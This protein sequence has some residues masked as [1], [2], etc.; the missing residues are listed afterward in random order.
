MRP[1]P[2][3][4]C[5]PAHQA[6]GPGQQGQGLLAGGVAGGEQLLVEVEEGHRVGA[7]HPV[8]HGLGADQDGARRARRR[9]SPA[10][11]S[12]T[13][14]PASSS[15]S[16][17]ARVT[18]T[19]SAFIRVAPQAV[20]TAGRVAPQRRQA[21]GAV[22]PASATGPAHTSHRAS[23]PQA[24]HA[25]SGARPLRLRTH[26]TRRSGPASRTRATRRDE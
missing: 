24:T 26:T 20:H 22:R 11:T 16:S 23:S 5:A 12:A 8:Q 4:A 25:S 10:V 2:P 1:P 15:S 3:P 21:E 9:P 19:R 18:P 17:R 6:G 14:R 7:G 13:G